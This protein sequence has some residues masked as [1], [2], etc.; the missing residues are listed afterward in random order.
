MDEAEGTELAPVHLAQELE[1]VDRGVTA[2]A[3]ALVEVAGLGT[4]PAVQARLQIER[5]L[6]VGLL[7]EHALGARD[8]LGLRQLDGRSGAREPRD[9]LRQSVEGPTLFR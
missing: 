8:A 2:L 7:N 9:A 6:R 4:H 5:D 1:L 3:G